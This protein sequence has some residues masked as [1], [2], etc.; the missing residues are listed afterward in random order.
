MILP[1]VFMSFVELLRHSQRFISSC[2]FNAV[3]PP[4]LLL[5]FYIMR[6]CWTNLRM[7]R[8]PFL[9]MQRFDFKNKTFWDTLS[10]I[11][12]KSYEKLKRM[13]WSMERFIKFTKTWVI[14]HK[15]RLECTLVHNWYVIT[16]LA[17][18][19]KLWKRL[20]WYLLIKLATW[21][22]QPE[23][24]WPFCTWIHKPFILSHDFLRMSCLKSQN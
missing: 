14:V 10:S 3:S 17:A 1:K 22:F 6:Y 24:L 11:R 20:T 8:L 16:L 15:I 19:K 2:C 23:V 9:E 5:I 7:L 4:I 21:Y 13:S 12:K 18:V